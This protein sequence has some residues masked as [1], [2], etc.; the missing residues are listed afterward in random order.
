MTTA[1]PT[2][3]ERAW[4][5]QPGPLTDVSAH[6]DRLQG[7][8]R[9]LESLC[10][11]VQGVLL[12]GHL[13]GLYGLELTEERRSVELNLRGA[14]DRLAAML[15]RDGRPLI[16]ARPPAERQLG[17]CRD[18][19]LLLCALLRWQGR[20]ARA[21]CGFGGYFS[22]GLFED[23]WVCEVWDE[24]G[25]RWRLV[26][27]QIDDVQRRFFGPKDSLDVSREEFVVGGEAWA[28]CRDGRLDESRYGLSTIHE[29]GLWFV[30]GDFVRD[31]AALN[32]VELLPWDIWG[33][34]LHP[35]LGP[36]SL[37]LA[38]DEVVA[39]LPA[40]DLAEL[41][42]VASL[43]SGPVDLAALRTAYGDPRWRVPE[44]NPALAGRGGA[45]PP[46]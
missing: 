7:L 13:G 21:R 35:A 22:P 46:E 41:D 18:F 42:R 23:H 20:T 16:E 34:M 37:E 40:D 30:C 5:A 4:Y 12:H 6:A 25:E 26:D 17:T 11:V 43:A 38:G 10:A 33:V 15:A 28:G 2:E 39:R 29:S 19:T 24:D 27:A 8:P 14:A 1:L 36:E 31:V 32:K 3:E 9:D 45:C 44:D